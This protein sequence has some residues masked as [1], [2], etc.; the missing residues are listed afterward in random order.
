MSKKQA[1]NYRE[2]TEN[3]CVTCRNRIWVNLHDAEARPLGQAY[4]CPVIGVDS[5]LP[6]GYTCD[7]QRPV[8]KV[9]S[10]VEPEKLQW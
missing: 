8:R 6:L 3:T 9:T 5:L 10:I 4:R 1:V 2:A 7:K